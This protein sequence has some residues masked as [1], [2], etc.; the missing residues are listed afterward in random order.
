M[1]MLEC[2]AAVLKP[3]GMGKRELETCEAAWVALSGS[4]RVS[5]RAA[6]DRQDFYSLQDF[7]AAVCAAFGLDGHYDISGFHVEALQQCGNMP[8]LKPIVAGCRSAGRALVGQ[9]EAEV[10]LVHL[11]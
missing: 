5:Q 1:L 10:A 7:L 2:A 6:L 9:V 4:T 3:R 8:W 11:G